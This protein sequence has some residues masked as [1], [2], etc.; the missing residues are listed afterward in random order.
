M[1]RRK[2]GSFLE[3]LTT[4]TAK[5]PWWVGVLLAVGTYLALHAAAQIEPP[6]PGSVKGLADAVGTTVIRTLAM[7][8]QYLIPIALVGAGVSAYQ[9]RRREQHA[10]I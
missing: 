9:R 2:S 5:A 6:P 3:D 8:L 7:F 1:G 10:H 4:V